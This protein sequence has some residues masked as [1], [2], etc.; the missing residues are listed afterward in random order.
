MGHNARASTKEKAEEEIEGARVAA[1][2]INE[3]NRLKDGRKGR[4]PNKGITQ[5]R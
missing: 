3:I 2:A 5:S 4:W 1:A